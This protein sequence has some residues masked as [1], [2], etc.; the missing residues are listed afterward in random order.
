MADQKRPNTRA[1][2]LMATGLWA[3]SRVAL[4]LFTY[5]TLL[6]H[7]S[8]SGQAATS[9]PALASAWLQWDAKWYV[10][11]AQMG[12]FN[13]QS[14]GFF[15]LYP[16]LVHVVGMALGG[17][18]LVA[19]LIV[20]NL[21]ALGVFIGL[22][23][24]AAHEF[25]SERAA[26][27]AVTMLAA[28]PLAFF[29]AAPYTEG[30]FIAL[31]AFTLY[32]ARTGRWR[33]AAVC[34]FFAALTRPTGIILLVPLV[35]EYGRQRDWWANWRSAESWH[36]RLGAAF[37]PRNWRQRG[38]ALGALLIMGAVPAAVALYML[39]LG[40]RFGDPLHYVHAQQRYWSHVGPGAPSTP[41]PTGAAQ[42]PA[43]PLSF[44]TP[45]YDQAR[46][47]VDLAPLVI[48]LILTII[49]V[50]RQPVIYTLYM[51]G[52]FALILASLR[53]DRLG[54][55]VAAGRYLCAALPIFF[56]LG[57]WSETRPW[58]YLLLTS[59]GFL[60]Q[61]TLATVFLAGGWLV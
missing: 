47:L 35:W 16:L 50:R 53:P 42:P 22:A 46:A 30:L 14:A 36:V 52:L 12:Y 15:P 9:S 27:Y 54:F 17:D 21:G 60:L 8:G 56:W 51:V 25:G 29:L 20:S 3:A 5:A 18:H 55:F 39:F 33:V 58:L 13:D 2:A 40:I 44:L 28:Y 41:V 1:V 49:L 61:A 45:S 34:A 10:Q 37:V 4:A 11:I 57:R 23:L 38:G 31:V 19:A 26:S 32:G 59:A 48:F 24:L 6:L 43:E 7:P